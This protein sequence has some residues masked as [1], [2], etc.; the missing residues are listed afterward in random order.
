MPSYYGVSVK[1]K[2]VKAAKNLLE[3]KNLLNKT[4]KISQDEDDKTHQLMII[5]T[6]LSV[7]N[8]RLDECLATL[9][10]I[11]HVNI[12]EQTAPKP[13]GNAFTR[14]L[15]AACKTLPPSF[16][17]PTES[18]T[19]EAITQDWTPSPPV[20]PPILLLKQHMLSH[21]PFKHLLEA[22]LS[23]RTDSDTQSRFWT[24]LCAPLGAT[25]VALDAP[26]PA[27]LSSASAS[28]TEDDSPFS[29]VL[30]SPTNF[31]PLHGAFGPLLPP[32]PAH[33]PTPADYTSAFWASA[34]QNGI[35]QTWAPRYTMFSAGNTSEKARILALPSVGDAANDPAGATAV[36]LFAGVG[37]FAFSYAKAGMQVV[38]AWDLNPWSTEGLRRGAAANRW[39]CHAVRVADTPP[40]ASPAAQRDAAR[41]DDD[42]TGA[43]LVVFTETNAHAPARVRALRSGIPPV[44]HVNC[45][46]LPSA[47]MAWRAACAVLDPRRGG[48]LH[49]H[50][51]VRTDGVDERAE[52][53]R[54]AVEGFVGVLSGGVEVGVTIEHVERVKSVAPRLVHVVVD[55]K[56][57]GC[58]RDEWV[59]VDVSEREGR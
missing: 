53:I 41:L 17:E 21:P 36:D 27:A 10:N 47:G 8:E 2:D 22:L 30:R 15:I 26:V 25:H 51:T 34:H 37:Y 43:R 58:G 56:V 33:S 50:E 32:S 16:W 55:L 20:Y 18:L 35:S 9:G 54:A 14:A 48:W 57:C 46:M 19:A 45:G 24:A 28:G 29:N 52:E 59:D 7:N 11:V 5:P 4:V 23:P 38:L 31:H 39:T 13:Q 1:K 40:D 49:L 3:S 44:R 42:N 12:D 6:T